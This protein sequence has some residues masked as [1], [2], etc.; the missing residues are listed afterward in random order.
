M[1]VTAGFPVNVP[2]T[3][4]AGEAL[5]TARAAPPATAPAATAAARVR[6]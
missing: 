6:T 2:G 4:A 1:A 5:V 3:A